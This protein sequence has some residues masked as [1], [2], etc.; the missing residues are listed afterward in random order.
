MG[1]PYPGA[2]RIFERMLTLGADLKHIEKT[3]GYAVLPMIVNEGE[4]IFLTIQIK[5]I[6]TATLN[7]AYDW[8]FIL[9]PYVAGSTPRFSARVPVIFYCAAANRGNLL[10]VLGA[11]LASGADPWAEVDVIIAHERFLG[12]RGS[13]RWVEVEKADGT[14]WRAS[15]AARYSWNWKAAKILEDWEVKH[16]RPAV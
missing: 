4:S 3:T 13:G 8:S 7:Q 15:V 6:D 12:E 2:V 10:P 14:E 1:G 5:N 9:H 11:L 16:P